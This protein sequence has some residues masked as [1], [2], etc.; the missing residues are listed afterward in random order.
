M[1][2]L[3]FLGNPKDPYG[4]CFFVPGQKKHVLDFWAGISSDRR[5][6][7][8]SPEAPKGL[9]S[10]ETRT[11]KDQE[12]HWGN[13]VLRQEENLSSNPYKT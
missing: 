10:W 5:P 1:E 9:R 6:G 3:E 8:G 11:P 12:I 2:S 4:T 7:R 13:N